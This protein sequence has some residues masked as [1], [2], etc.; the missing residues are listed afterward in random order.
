MIFLWDA[1]MKQRPVLLAG[2]IF[3]SGCMRPAWPPPAP[4]EDDPSISFPE[5]FEHAAISVEAGATPY[6]LDGVVLRAI[7]VAMN[8]YVRPDLR[9][10]TC[11]GS[12]EAH[13]YRV[14]RQEKIIFVRIDEDLEAC[15]LQ[16]VSV[17]SGAKYAVS[18]DG[19]ILRRAFDGSPGRGLAPIAPDAGLPARAM[20]PARADGGSAPPLSGPPDAGATTPD[21]GVPHGP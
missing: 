2:A 4:V 1:L 5:F 15:G 7:M 13:R 11:W 9:E 8:D 20:P 3:L 14:I 21:G 18:L 19:R 17:D 12:P 6:E 10:Q 16:Y